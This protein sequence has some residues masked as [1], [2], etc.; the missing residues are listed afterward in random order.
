M[1]L[2]V[3]MRVY[4]NSPLTPDRSTRDASGSRKPLWFVPTRTPDSVSPLPGDDRNVQSDCLLQSAS[5]AGAPNTLFWRTRRRRS[6]NRCSRP[7]VQNVELSFN[8]S[9][10]RSSPRRPKSAVEPEAELIVLVDEQDRRVGLAQKME[11]HVHG[12][13]HRAFSVFVFNDRHE[14]LLQKRAPVKYHSG[15]LWTN[16]CCGHPRP[17]EH[18]ARAAH[19]RLHEEMGFDCDL[20]RIGAIQ[21][22]LE[23]GNGLVER[24]YLHL[25]VGQW[26]GQPAPAADEVS[27]WRWCAPSAVDASLATQASRFTAWLPLT[28]P[29]VRQALQAGVFS[30]TKSTAGMP[31]PP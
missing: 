21:Y 28:W 23:V 6:A 14:L 22:A 19:R 30:P 10:M 18:V 26:N 13:R 20:L 31:T 5:A 9:P 25:F 12:W 15:G 8:P 3:M 1:S 16:T 24:E 29:H 11:A 7:T 27:D 2:G 17:G 4:L